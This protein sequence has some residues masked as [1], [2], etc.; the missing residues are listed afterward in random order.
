MVN[1]HNCVHIVSVADGAGY[2]K[3]NPTGGFDL[4][5]DGN[6]R[7]FVAIPHHHARALDAEQV[8]P[9]PRPPP[10]TTATW[11]GMPRSTEHSYELLPRCRPNIA[12]MLAQSSAAAFSSCTVRSGKT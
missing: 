4:A 7:R 5:S 11:P 8:L 10:L 9:M 2:G 6:S 12:N 1:H 3:R